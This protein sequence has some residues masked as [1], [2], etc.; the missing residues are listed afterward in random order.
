[1][2]GSRNLNGGSASRTHQQPWHRPPLAER[3]WFSDRYTVLDPYGFV[4]Y[5]WGLRRQLPMG[6]LKNYTAFKDRMIERPAVRR[7]VDGEQ[8]GV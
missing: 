2:A 5:T 4:F 3:E 1:L 6:E 8:I 7:V